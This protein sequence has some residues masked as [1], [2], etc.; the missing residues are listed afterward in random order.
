M[1]SFPRSLVFRILLLC[2]FAL[3]AFGVPSASTAAEPAENALDFVTIR[4]GHGE[5]AVLVVGG[6]QG[7]EPG[8]FSAATL[9]GTR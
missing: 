3:Y 2:C 5:R 1:K 8:G 9:V 4:L 6:I 7:D